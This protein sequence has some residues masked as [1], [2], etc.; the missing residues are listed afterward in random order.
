ML[1]TNS[2]NAPLYCLVLLVEPTGV[3]IANDIF[4]K[5]LKMG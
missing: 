4:G 2:K 1:M 5:F 3:R